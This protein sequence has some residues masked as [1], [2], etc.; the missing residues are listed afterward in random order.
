MTSPT[1]QTVIDQVVHN[2]SY[3]KSRI[4]K[5]STLQKHLEEK[6]VLNVTEVLDRMIEQ[7]ILYEPK[8]GF[9]GFTKPEDHFIIRNC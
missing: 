6:G 8:K 2:C 3:W 1:E 5:R 9:I 4:C 7:K